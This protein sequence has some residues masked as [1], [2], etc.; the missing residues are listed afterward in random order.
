VQA[1]LDGFVSVQPCRADLT[2]HDALE[3]LALA[4]GD[5]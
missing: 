2:A 4:L 5:G 3:G 1:N